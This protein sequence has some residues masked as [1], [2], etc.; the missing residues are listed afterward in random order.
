M[1]DQEIV[2]FTDTF[3]EAIKKLFMAGGF[4]LAFG[5]A[6]IIMI[7]GA[8]IFGQSDSIILIII[9]S[10]LTFSCLGFFLFS[11]ITGDL[12]TKKVLSD[13]KELM[14]AIQDLSIQLTKLVSIAQS[15]SFKNIEKINDA[16]N[17]A[18]PKIK[19]LPFIGDKVSEYGLDNAALISQT[20]VDSGEKI[21]IIVNEIQQSLI[22]G[23][24]SKLKDYSKELANLI[25]DIKQQLKKA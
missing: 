22:E 16:S 13:N 24:H 1:A 20:I 19:A 15:Y 6:G 9:G 23:D 17:L 21:D 14:D 3:S 25:E 7:L 18:I 11:T 10:I 4:A 8:K 5:F 12:A 2:R